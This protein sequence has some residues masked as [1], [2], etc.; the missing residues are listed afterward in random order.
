MKH[1]FLTAVLIVAVTAGRAAN[2]ASPAFDTAVRHSLIDGVE[3]NVKDYVIADRIP[4]AEAALE[5]ARQSLE[6]I[7]DPRA[8]AKAVTETLYSATHD[9][10]MFLAY[11]ETAVQTNGDASYMKTLSTYTGE[12]VGTFARLPGNIG[13]LDIR[14]NFTSAEESAHAFAAMMTLAANTD[15]L[16]VD[17]RKNGGGGSANHLLLSYFVPANTPLTSLHFRGQPPLNVSS[18]P[19]LKGPRYLTKPVFVLTGPRTASAAEGFA[20]ALQ[21]LHRATIVGSVTAGAG[22]PNKM[23]PLNEHFVV[24]VAIGETINPYTKTGWEGVGV[25]PDV[26][27]APSDALLRSYALA[28]QQAKNDFAP[29]AARRAEALG[30]PAAALASI[31]LK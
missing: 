26:A 27:T 7:D 23:T 20:Y 3:R 15:A 9:K 13:Y 14:P 10:H 11:R 31:G 25:Q 22:N 30:D 18:Y 28:L 16:I 19:I 6:E 8:F 12:G 1:L 4:R 29:I 24:S 5:S 17:V 21:A 2:A